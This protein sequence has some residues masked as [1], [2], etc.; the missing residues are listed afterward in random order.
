[1]AAGD[2]EQEVLELIRGAIELHLRSR[3]EDGEPIPPPVSVAAT[4][5]VAANRQNPYS[6]PAT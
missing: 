2:T 4:V 3:R 5:E 1:M 6:A